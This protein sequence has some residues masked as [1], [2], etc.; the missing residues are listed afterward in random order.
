MN[1]S[2]RA[3]RDIGDRSLIGPHTEGPHPVSQQKPS[4]ETRNKAATRKNAVRVEQYL[5]EIE[6]AHGCA[7]AWALRERLELGHVTLEELRGR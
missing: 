7:R 6:K 3:A 5:T 4:K 2:A 1:D